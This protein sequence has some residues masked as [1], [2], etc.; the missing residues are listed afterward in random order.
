M[1]CFKQLDVQL[2]TARGQRNAVGEARVE[3]GILIAKRIRFAPLPMQLRANLIA[4]LVLPSSLYGYSVAG[5]TQTLM[6]GLRSEWAVLENS[7]AKR[8]C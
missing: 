8:L 3:K 7:G 2:R 1:Q 6:N 4:S 5:L